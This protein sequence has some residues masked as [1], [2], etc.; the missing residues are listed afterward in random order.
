ME[1]IR[2]DTLK[3]MRMI[4]FKELNAF[5]KFCKSLIG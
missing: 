3:V 1:N 2:N 5:E 4:R